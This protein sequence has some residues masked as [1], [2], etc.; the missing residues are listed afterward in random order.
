VECDAC[1]CEMHDRARRVVAEA[2]LLD[3]RFRPP[4]VPSGRPPGILLRGDERDLCL[5]EEG[6]VHGA[7]G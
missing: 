3:Q 7:D 2:R 4:C 5:R 6:V 1:H